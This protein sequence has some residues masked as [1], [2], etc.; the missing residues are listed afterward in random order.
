LTG[1]LFQSTGIC[2]HTVFDVFAFGVFYHTFDIFANRKSCIPQE[3]TIG[4]Q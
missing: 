2:A 3:E 1:Q 4:W